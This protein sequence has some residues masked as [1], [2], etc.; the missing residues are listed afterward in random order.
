M[1][2]ALTFGTLMP[3][4]P[5]IDPDPDVIRS[6]WSLIRS[7]GDRALREAARQ[8]NAMIERG[9]QRAVSLWWSIGQAIQELRRT[10]RAPHEPL[11]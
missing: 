11:N 5:L 1:R 4:K 7:H 3:K 10:K 8:Q 2:V 9:D 6:A